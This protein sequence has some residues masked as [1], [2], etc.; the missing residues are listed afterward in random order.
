MILMRE[1]GHSV[2]LFCNPN[3]QISAIAKKYDFEIIECKMNKKNYIYTI[4][5]FIKVIKN[6]KI[7]LVITHGSTDSWIGAISRFF[8]KKQCKF[9]RERHNLFSIKG[10]GSKIMHKTMFDAIIYIS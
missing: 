1:I 5:K 4:L 9:A 2:I 6:K 8:C 7:E 3:S 10:I